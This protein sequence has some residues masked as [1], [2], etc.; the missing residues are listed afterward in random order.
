M[1][2]HTISLGNQRYLVDL[3]KSQ[4]DIA[5]LHKS[6]FVMLREIDNTTGQLRDKD[7]YIFPKELLDTPDK[8]IYPCV[9]SAFTQFSTSVSKFS[10][11]LTDDRLRHS[12]IDLYNAEKDATT[13]E[14]TGMSEKSVL[15]D[16]I[17]VYHPHTIKKTNGI[18]HV[19]TYLNN[20]HVHL[21]ARDLSSGTIGSETEIQL[22]NIYYSEYVEFFIPS[23]EDL[24]GGSTFYNE[25]AFV[26]KDTTGANQIYSPAN[27]SPLVVGNN[28]Y[29][30]LDII[31]HPYTTER[32]DGHL[33][34]TYYTEDTSIIKENY[35]IYPVNIGIYPYSELSDCI[36]IYSDSIDPKVTQYVDDCRITMRSK[37]G[38]S[39]GV[40]SVLNEFN[41]PEKEKFSS[42]A[43]AYQFYNGVDL[44]NY[45]GITVSSDEDEDY[46]DEDP[47][48]K[49]Q[50]QCS[51]TLDIYTDLKMRTRLFHDSMDI[52]DP[53]EDLDEIGWNI[54]GVF[55]SWD[56]FN[57]NMVARCKFTDRYLGKV[58]YGNPVVIT[59]EWFKYIV[60]DTTQKR[61]ASITGEQERTQKISE[62]D[63]SKFNFIDKIQCTVV[64]NKDNTQM[65]TGNK[66]V[67][68]TL[69]KPIFFRT[70]DLQNVKLVQGL[71]QNIGINLSEYMT[72]V[73][74]FK[75]VINNTQ[76]IETGR[77]D[78]YV[79]FNV[80]ASAIDYAN[81][82]YHILD[83]DDE[84]ISSGNW[85]IN[86]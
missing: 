41:Y 77:N 42:F 63:I 72:K 19:D 4:K 59:K 57:D 11:N 81:G 28:Q 27:Q 15:C 26:V 64:N 30:Q 76:F 38:F 23:L 56:D 10:D 85:T 37:L 6:Q 83:Q 55:N 8:I 78:V 50:P 58:I 12:V 33:E 24:L 20:I 75:M 61:R 70:Y 3:Y 29:V 45:T 54:F 32:I 46:T 14:L 60:G 34:R 43:E 51:F 44:A 40:V 49:L 48:E 35:T 68:R 39:S 79:I 2:R 18:I 67:S 71:R 25:R 7:L 36:Y 65:S 5:E 74:T 53:A 47:E 1:I 22:D 31:R 86:R 69:Y 13:G 9:Q 21:L 84:Y 66:Q 82:T 73:E 17:R 52:D 62:M 80:D 16:K